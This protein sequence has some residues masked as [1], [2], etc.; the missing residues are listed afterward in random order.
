MVKPKGVGFVGRV[1]R[2]IYRTLDLSG[3]DPDTTTAGPLLFA[4]SS[5]STI[6]SST[7]NTKFL[8]LYL[9][10]SATSG[11]NRGIYNRLYL[12]GAAGGGESFRAF[13]T[14]SAA[15]GTAH[16]AHISLNFAGDT[17]GELS[18][19]GVAVRST[20]HIPDDAAWEG[21]TLSAL[22]AE[23]YSD[24]AASDPDGLTEL[25]FLRII[26]DGNA[27]GVADVDDDAFLLS[28][29]GFEVGAG[30][31][32]AA[33]SSAAVSHT[34]RIKIGDTTYYLMVSDTQ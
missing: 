15:C 9:E 25:S 7:A 10:S 31:V 21:G 22:Q 24:G 18:G 8:Q 32:I 12:T 28:L 19:L 29:Q 34:L 16:G 11:D 23:I 13:T 20:L 1:R 27:S 6:S 5:S 26:N 4:G 30:N 14:V 33:K 2:K 17:T 3:I